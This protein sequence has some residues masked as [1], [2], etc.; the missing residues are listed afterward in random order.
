MRP[1]QQGRALVR[2]ASD[3]DQVKAAKK[4]ER[5][6]RDE[7]LNDIRATFGQD[8]PF[9]YQARR[10]L[11]RLLGEFK[12]NE[13][14]FVTSSEIYYRAGRQD[15]GH[16]LMAEVLEADP[17]LYLLMQREAIQ[18]RKNEAPEPEPSKSD[19]DAGE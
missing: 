3:R 4:S 14:I 1:N 6:I 11:W 8:S 5:F 9:G 17:E 18:R 7:Q 19:D 13:S 10:L 12:V 2:N 16:F 15:A